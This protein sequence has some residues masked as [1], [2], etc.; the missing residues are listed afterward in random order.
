MRS[1][2]IRHWSLVALGLLASVACAQEQVPGTLSGYAGAPA[3]PATSGYHQLVCRYHDGETQRAMPFLLYL[4]EG[5]GQ[6]NQKWPLIVCLSGIGERGED[7]RMLYMWGIA[8]DLLEK[9]DLQ[10]WAP[11]VILMP[12]CPTDGTWKTPQVAK[13]VDQL[14]QQV[15]TTWSVDDTKVYLTGL[16][17][18]GGGCWPVARLS[19]KRYAAI[20]SFSGGTNEPDATAT[21]LEGSGTTC[22]IVS[23]EADPRS[24]VGSATMAK[25][26]RGAGLD[27][28]EVVVPNGPHVLWPAYYADQR[29]YDWLL[30]HQRGSLPPQNRMTAGQL[31]QIGEALCK[32]D[33]LRQKLDEELQMVARYWLVDNWGNTVEPGLRP[34][35]GGR[36]NV[37]VTA[38]KSPEIPCRLQTTIKLPSPKPLLHLEVGHHPQG[39]WTLVVQVNEKVALEQPVGSQFSRDSWMTLDTDLSAY[40]GQ[41]VRL[42]LV[43][44]P[45]G[46]DHHEA[47]WSKVEITGW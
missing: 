42:Q 43:V 2:V 28:V 41:E 23:G 3:H 37:Y 27:V 46:K 26:L 36:K 38:P 12:Q 44:L 18:G 31:A 1:L 10:K 14:I 47:Y 5:Y 19:P 17:L 9:P 34:N 11:F 16:S 39:N 25:A 29:F 32:P 33:P 8:H 45:A 24:A 6:Q 20:A 35:L 40:A 15:M 22:L 4:P 30:L 21:A 13:A 7:P